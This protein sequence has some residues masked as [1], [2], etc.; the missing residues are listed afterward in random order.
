MPHPS[1]TRRHLRRDS[2]QN[3]DTQGTFDRWQRQLDA[4]DLLQGR[5][6]QLRKQPERPPSYLDPVTAPQSLSSIPSPFSSPASDDP[7]NLSQNGEDEDITWLL[8]VVLTSALLISLASIIRTCG[9]KVNW[10]SASSSNSGHGGAHRN[11]GHGHG[12]GRGPSRYPGSGPHQVPGEDDPDPD[13]GLN[14]NDERWALMTEAQ[15][16]AFD[17]TR[18]NAFLPSLTF[19][20]VYYWNSIRCHGLRS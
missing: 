4:A 11:H 3:Y 6:Q 13:Q 5:N 18:G 15:R 14:E 16:Q 7:Q 12:P 2:H 9:Q 10:L 8:A 17:S 19:T 20:A 1:R